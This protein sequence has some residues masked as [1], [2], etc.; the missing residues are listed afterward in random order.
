MTKLT[1]LE[2]CDR[3]YEL[4]SV[5]EN[6]SQ[7]DLPPELVEAMNSLLEDRNTATE[8]YYEKINSILNLIKNKQQWAKIRKER[9]KEL[10]R[11][12]RIDE[13]LA[14]KVNQYLLDHL[15]R[16]KKTK[17]RT[18]DFNVSVAQ[19]G[20][21]KPLKISDN[22]DLET[23]PQDLIRVKKELSKE[24][25]RDRLEKGEKLDFACFGERGQHLK[26]N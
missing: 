13:H 16:K 2:L 14:I 19:N 11:L 7:E 6:I 4:D 21:Q 1:L 22:I 3:L 15:S 18:K 10:Q 24:A 8:E 17:L 5:I 9:I 23:I 12:V 26:I 25:V 20:G